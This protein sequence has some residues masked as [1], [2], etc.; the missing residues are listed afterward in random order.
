MLDSDYEAFLGIWTEAMELYEK[1][2]SPGAINLAFRALQM[3]DLSE[4][5]QALT[6]HI[7]NPDTGQF[8]PKPAD[9]I[10]F[11]RGNT[12]SRTSL[13]WAKVEKAIRS[14]GH[15]QS[16]AFDDP[17][18]HAAI[19][20]LGGW[21]KVCTASATEKD[22]EFLGKKFETVYR[23]YAVNPPKTWPAVL[24]GEAEQTNSR[25]LGLQRGQLPA[26]YPVLIG[27]EEKALKVIKEGREAIGNGARLTIH[28]AAIQRLTQ[29][30]V[31]GNPQ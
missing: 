4:V 9:I 5:A 24:S 29:D 6:A 31:G 17:Y 10:K 22:L 20:Q 2:P 16:A 21:V 23:S 19:E 27:L 8:M 7:R 11:A 18:I 1:A 28:S 30:V 25:L 14:V 26:T 15:Y 3:L 12:E 13:A